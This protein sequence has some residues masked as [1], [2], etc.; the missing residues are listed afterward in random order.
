[1][2]NVI[3]I[4]ATCAIALVACEASEA[5]TVEEI[6]LTRIVETD[7]AASPTPTATPSPL[8]TSTPTSTHTPEPQPTPTAAP[9][10]E[11]A[12]VSD[13]E[14]ALKDTGY[15]RFPFTNDD[16]V[17]GFYW[18]N[19]NPYERVTTW[20]DGTIRMQVL[21]NDAPADRAERMDTHLKVLDTVLPAGFMSEL[22]REHASYNRSVPA[23]VTGEPDWID[24]FGD[25]WQTV[26]AKYNSSEFDLGG[27]NV[28]FSLRW[29]QSTCPP[30]YDY[31]YYSD[32]PGLEFTGDSSF[33]FHTILIWLPGG[34]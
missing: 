9:T 25:D 26:W 23:S 34:A 22:R 1:M 24:A 27:Y 4:L 33:I 14:T 5:L 16:G 32:F 11:T 7:M 21:H 31:C 19:T 30:Q 8:P 2:K 6:A 12:A 13:I 17:T 20:D 29:L 18:A 15:R 3:T 28:E 10:W